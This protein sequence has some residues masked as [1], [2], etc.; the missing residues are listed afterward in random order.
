MKRSRLALLVVVVVLVGMQAIRPNRDNPPVTGDLDA[1]ADVKLVLR[2]SCYDC[3][4]N[5]TRWPWYTNI[6]PVSW[7][8]A[9]HVK[10]GRAE[11]NFSEWSSYEPKK[12][13][14]KLEEIEDEVHEG[15]MPIGNYVWIHGDAK[16]SAADSKLIQEWAQTR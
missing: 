7:L 3:H 1:P 2:R 5:E 11:L 14:H 15:E 9:N 16:L 10:E 12:R 8:V 6:A 13:E 4:S